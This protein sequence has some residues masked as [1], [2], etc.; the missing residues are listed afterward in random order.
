MSSLNI[1][2]AHVCLLTIL[3]QISVSKQIEISLCMI[4][5]SN[6]YFHLKVK[7]VLVF[8]LY[9]SL[10]VRSFGTQCISQVDQ[11]V[12]PNDVVVVCISGL[13]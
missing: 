4:L 11:Y 6:T 1:F 10:H 9:S 2:V 7:C 5:V 8:A 13:L 3:M 12:N